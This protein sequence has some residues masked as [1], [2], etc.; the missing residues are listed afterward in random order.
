[1]ETIEREILSKLSLFY[2]Q[3]KKK[4]NSSELPEG[5]T[6][7]DFMVLNSLMN[8]KKTMVEISKEINVTQSSIT[9][10]ISKLEEKDIVKRIRY[11]SD[12]RITFVE[13]TDKGKEVVSSCQNKLNVVLLECIG[14]LSHAEKRNLLEV[15]KKLNC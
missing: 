9:L 8:G 11:P 2:I 10:S 6:I 5:L 1:V 13:I 7:T 4:L 12:R 15:L 3:V 14:N